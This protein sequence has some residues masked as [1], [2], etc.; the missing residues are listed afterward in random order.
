MRP[1]HLQQSP[2]SVPP[3]WTDTSRC[4]YLGVLKETRVDADQSCAK[5]GEAGIQ[6]VPLQRDMDPPMS[7]WF[8]PVS[9]VLDSVAHAAK[10]QQETMASLAQ[11][12]R[13]KCHQQRGLIDRMKNEI[14]EIKALRKAVEELKTENEQLRK[15]AQY[16]KEPSQEQ[17]VNGKRRML[18]PYR[19]E[20]DPRTTSSPRSIVTPL[21]P[22]RLTLPPSQVQPKFSGGRQPEQRA[23]AMMSHG[24]SN[25]H[26]QLSHPGN[27]PG[28]SRFM[29]YVIVLSFL[30]SRYFCR[31]RQYAY[32]TND[33]AVLPPVLSHSQAAPIRQAQNRASQSRPDQL[34]PQEGTWRS[35]LPPP[36]S[37]QPKRFK[38]SLGGPP[39][40]H[41]DMP[42]PPTPQGQATYD[43]P[44]N[45]AALHQSSSSASRRFVPP[46][47]NQSVS[48][49]PRTNRRFIPSAPS[50]G[51]TL[52]SNLGYSGAPHGIS[53][54]PSRAMGSLQL[55]ESN[56]R[57]PFIPGPES[58]QGAG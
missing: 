8:R 49:T 5:C 39:R 34:Q 28:S 23:N 25:S 44:H 50:G 37:G 47:P 43:R 19:Y 22:D 15:Y 33:T 21:G 41:L 6:V 9:D 12:Y 38:S 11:Y 45:P 54:T 27:R 1:C 30:V 52:S 3:C 51:P 26:T 42:P 7:D 57:M 36:P 2:E 24:A 55:Q 56:Q 20:D 16:S 10:F 48:M 4:F 13:T 29:Q 18:D 14:I 58:R 32:T 17:N 40:D 53:R 35:M 31:S 46:A